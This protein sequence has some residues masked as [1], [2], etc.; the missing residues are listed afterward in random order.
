[1]RCPLDKK[2]ED[3]LEVLKQFY[4]DRWLYVRDTMQNQK[5]VFVL[6]IRSHK[7]SP[8]FPLEWWVDQNRF[9]SV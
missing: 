2:G 7:E 8:Y 4:E 5:S 1:M 9:F 3:W 6:Q